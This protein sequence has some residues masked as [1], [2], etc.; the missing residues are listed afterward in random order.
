MLLSINSYNLYGKKLLKFHF[1]YPLFA[2]KFVPLPFADT[3]QKNNKCIEI[4]MQPHGYTPYLGRER[5]ACLET[6]DRKPK[7]QG[8]PEEKAGKTLTSPVSFNRFIL[9]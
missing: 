4:L 3:I 5:Y 8:H 1:L 9:N 2:V 7:Y 6:Q